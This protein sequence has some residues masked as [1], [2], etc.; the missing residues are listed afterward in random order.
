MLAFSLCEWMGGAMHLDVQDLK[1]F[2]YRQT[3]GRVAQR[4]IRTRLLE[5][6][7]DATGQTVV[8]YGFAVPLLRPYL[9]H[10]RRVIGLM[11]APQGVMPWPAGQPNVSVLCHEHNWPIETGHVDRLVIMHGLE[12]S[13]HP[14]AMLEETR[15][16]LGPGG[17]VM[18]I[19]PNRGGLWSRS[20]LTPM[21]F[22]RPYSLGQLE[23]MLR[24]HGFSTERHASALYIPPS[25]RRIWQK[26]GPMLE[27]VGRRSPFF[28]GGV[29]L[30][31]ATTR[32]NIPKGLTQRQSSRAS[33][34]VLGGF[35][36]PAPRPVPR[37]FQGREL[38]NLTKMG[39]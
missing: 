31:E 5:L 36:K 6:W 17:R 10:A 12:V 32:V 26:M 15:R 18:F 27:N 21:G 30:I 8:G 25:H 38:S 14:S 7:P 22:G 3:L 11:P 13:D 28:A 39:G 20:D 4:A 33:L 29:L 24:L 9:P 23:N 2:Y 35:G 34:A 19:V 1:N 37:S 16:V